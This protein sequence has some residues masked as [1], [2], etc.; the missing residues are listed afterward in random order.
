MKE[1]FNLNGDLIEVTANTPTINK[2]GVRYLLTL[3]QQEQ[4]ATKKTAH[5]ADSKKRNASVEIQRLETEVTQRRFR[6]ATLGI[7][8]GWLLNQDNLIS[9]ERAKLGE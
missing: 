3:E 2:G 9:V 7:D 6:E 4:E 8:D 1:A 5:E